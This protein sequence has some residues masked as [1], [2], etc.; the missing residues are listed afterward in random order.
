MVC[1]LALIADKWR[2]NRLEPRQ[3]VAGDTLEN[4]RMR[5]RAAP[6]KSAG[7]T[8]LSEVVGE[9]C[10]IMVF[11]HSK[12]PFCE[13]LGE[14]W[15]GA[16]EIVYDGVSIPVAWTSVSAHDDGAAEFVQR[17][18]LPVPWFSI[19]GRKDRVALGVSGWPTIYLLSPGGVFEQEMPR[20][21]KAGVDLSANCRDAP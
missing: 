18:G 6:G 11:F 19:R 7:D 10:G 15:A 9:R 4:V 17:F 2:T 13:H 5:I 1:Q 8:W 3:V 12:C 20:N 16:T 14:E 21:R